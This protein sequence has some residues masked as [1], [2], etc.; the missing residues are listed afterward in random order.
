MDEKILRELK[1]WFENYVAS[2]KS[3]DAEF[4]RNIILKEDHTRRVCQEI[5][6]IGENIG[7]DSKGLQLAEI[8]A[9]FH[10]V[11][12]FEQFAQYG[13]FADHIS[14]NHAK[15]GVDILRQKGIL[16]DLDES[17]QGLILRSISYH[18]R[19]DLP[20][21][22][23]EACLHFSK[24]LRDADKLDIWQVFADYYRQEGEKANSILVHS[25]PDTPGISPDI[26]SELVANRIANYTD[27]KNLNDFKLLQVGWVYDINF[28]P[29]FRRIQERGYLDA[30]RRALPRS[31]QV[32]RIL[33]AAQAYLSGFVTENTEIVEGDSGHLASPIG[34]KQFL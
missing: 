32:E 24:I 1:K 9:L 25:F 30:I 21:K 5:L 8:M 18:N 26:Y 28:P 22:E 33:S 4:D 3:G 29:A 16:K 23:T 7:L 12:R 17:D 15:L 10:D 19:R 31:E 2:F 20:E 6:Y 11:G 34:V 27:V 14:V 13:T